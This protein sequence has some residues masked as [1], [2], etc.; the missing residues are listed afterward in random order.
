MHRLIFQNGF[1]ILQEVAPFH[2]WRLPDVI[3]PDPSVSLN[4]C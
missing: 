1:I 4:K 2:K 3:G